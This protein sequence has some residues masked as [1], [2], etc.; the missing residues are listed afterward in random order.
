MRR[1]KVRPL[2]ASVPESEFA[3]A[4]VVVI[5][6]LRASSTICTALA[7]GAECVMPFVEVAETL[8]A[9]EKFGRANVL[10]G[11]ERGGKL[12]EGFDLGNSP[13]EYTPERVAGRRI[14][15][16]TTN[17][18]R[19][20][21]HARLADRVVVGSLLN[22]RAAAAGSLGSSR[23]EILCAG[24]NG[25]ETR[26]DLLAAGA[27]VEAILDSLSPG[28]AIDALATLDLNDAALAAFHNWSKVKGGDLAREL[29]DSHGGRNLLDIGLGRDLA[30]CA[31]LDK[32]EVVPLFDPASGEIRP[33]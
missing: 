6:L 10:L 25:V 19:A 20:L 12:I 8:A 16:T 22:R 26:E 4:T 31:E 11:G 33:A 17:G 32:L 5:D 24:T 13:A 1:L 3:G 15:F 28:G 7:A 30:D 18:A 9:A 14:L 27:F 29:G 23:V 2:P 21:H